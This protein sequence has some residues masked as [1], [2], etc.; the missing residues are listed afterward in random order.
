MHIRWSLSRLELGFFD[1]IFAGVV[2]Q[3]IVHSPN[4][5]VGLSLVKIP[6][7]LRMNDLETPLRS[8]FR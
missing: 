7:N 5:S 8:V 4:Q 3:N 2:R 1:E 6:C